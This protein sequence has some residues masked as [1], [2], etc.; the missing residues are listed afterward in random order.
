MLQGLAAGEQINEEPVRVLTAYKSSTYWRHGITAFDVNLLYAFSGLMI[1]SGIA[2][3]LGLKAPYGKFTKSNMLWDRFFTEP[4]VDY[5]SRDFRPRCLE[6][7]RKSWSIHTDDHKFLPS[8]S[9]IRHDDTVSLSV[10]IT[11][12]PQNSD[13]SMAQTKEP[14]TSSIVCDADGD[15]V[16]LDDCIPEHQIH[17]LR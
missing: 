6:Y 2:L 16:Q 11:L 5:C 17:D 4:Q 8:A 12:H 13:L 10:G 7:T 15:I 1:L 3:F 9:D 14:C